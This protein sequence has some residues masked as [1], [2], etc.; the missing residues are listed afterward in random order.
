MTFQFQPPANSTSEKVKL[1]LT[2][3]ILSWADGLA[4]ASNSTREEVLTQAVAYAIT[5]ASRP[6]RKRVAKKGGD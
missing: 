3:E 2:P 1:A 6:V 4:S 5:S